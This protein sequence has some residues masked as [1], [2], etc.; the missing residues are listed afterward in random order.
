MIAIDKLLG[1][2]HDFLEVSK[3]PDP[4]CLN[5]LQVAGKKDI[6]KIALAVTASTNI[7][8]Q[9]A[10]WGADAL[11]VHHGIFWGKGVQSVDRILGKRLRPLLENDIN[12]C[13]YHLPLDA[14][15]SIGNNAQIASRFG[16]YDVMMTDICTV[17]NFSEPLPF[18]DFTQQAKEMFGEIVCAKKFASD[19][20]SRLGICSG[21]GGDFAQKCFEAGADTFLVGEVSEQHWHLFA[22][23][24]MNFVAVGHYSSERFGIQELGLILKEHHPFLEFSFFEELCPI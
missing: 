1:F 8:E 22:E 2:C 19:T 10:E 24:P 20:V 12:L 16:L 4:Y 21:G 11:L 9:A 13:A 3:I 14:H 15:P 23:L 18:S 6:Q 17:G 7:I 5:G